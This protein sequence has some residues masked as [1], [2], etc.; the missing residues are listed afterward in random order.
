M[1][2]K[3]ILSEQYLSDN[4]R[5]ADLCNYFIYGGEQ[6]IKPGDLKPLPNAESAI[7]QKMNELITSK[8]LRDVIKGVTIKRGIFIRFYQRK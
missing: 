4:D 6:V 1:G 8:K 7:I 5:F 2:K 3:D